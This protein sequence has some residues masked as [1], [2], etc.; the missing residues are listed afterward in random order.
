MTI[1]KW[2]R[3]LQKVRKHCGNRRNCSLWA[4]YSFPTV[5][6][7]DLSTYCRHVKNQGLLGKGLND[8]TCLDVIRFKSLQYKR[9][10]CILPPASKSGSIHL[11]VDITPEKH[12]GYS[13]P[14]M[15]LYMYESYPCNRM[16]CR[17]FWD[18]NNCAKLINPCSMTTTEWCFTPISS[19]FIIHVFPGFHH[20]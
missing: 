16:Y 1:L 5:F 17:A 11:K 4:I 10:F 8:M 13:Y 19:F 18:I 6:S 14:K 12:E 7:K 15:P 3:V 20:Y 2:Q 9:R